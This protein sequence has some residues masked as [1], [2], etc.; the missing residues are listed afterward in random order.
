M[1][2]PNIQKYLRIRNKL[3][4][5]DCGNETKEE[6]YVEYNELSRLRLLV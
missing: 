2:R 3:S 5:T 4:K 6:I 1:D